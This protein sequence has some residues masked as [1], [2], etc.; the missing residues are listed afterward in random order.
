MTAILYKQKNRGKFTQDN[1]KCFT[2]D[3]NRETGLIYSHK[4]V[5][6]D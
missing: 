3:R 6:V 1:L 4:N 2:E 5:R